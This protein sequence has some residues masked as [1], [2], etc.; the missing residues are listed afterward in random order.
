[1]RA[2]IVT[3]AGHREPAGRRIG[4]GSAG[5]RTANPVDDLVGS[6]RLG[7]EAEERFLGKVVFLRVEVDGDALAGQ[8]RHPQPPLDHP[9]LLQRRDGEGADVGVAAQPPCM[10]EG[11]A[12]GEA[13]SRR[14]RAE[15]RVE[16]LGR[17]QDALEQAA[18]FEIEEQALGL[19]R[20]RRFELL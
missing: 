2:Q 1:V 10:P 4:G 3:A 18:A 20:L 12:H 13:A 19:A 15:L 14:N 6:Q 11:R 17:A 5:H 9:V 7:A 8:P 16:A